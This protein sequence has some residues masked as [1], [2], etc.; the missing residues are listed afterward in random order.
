MYKILNLLKFKNIYYYF[1]LKFIRSLLYGN[2]KDNLNIYY[3]LKHH[4]EARYFK[5]YLPK[6]RL[7]IERTFLAYYCVSKL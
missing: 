5:L 1:C 6:I 7:E 3:S 4:Y 2:R